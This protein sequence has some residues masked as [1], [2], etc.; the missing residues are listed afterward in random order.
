MEK[1]VSKIELFD[2]RGFGL[3]KSDT[4]KLYQQAI[5][6]GKKIA[7]V[8]DKFGMSDRL[9][10]VLNQ[11]KNLP[12]NSFIPNQ[13][14]IYDTKEV[15]KF[16]LEFHQEISKE[17]KNILS[18]LNNISHKDVS[19]CDVIFL[20]VKTHLSASMEEIILMYFYLLNIGIRLSELYVVIDYQ[21]NIFDFIETDIFLRDIKENK[22]PNF[23]PENPLHDLERFQETNYDIIFQHFKIHYLVS[24]MDIYSKIVT[25]NNSRNID[26]VLFE[27]YEEYLLRKEKKLLPKH[28]TIFIIKIKSFEK[29][30]EYEKNKIDPGLFIIDTRV[31]M[32]TSIHYG[33]NISLPKKINNDYLQDR[34]E[35]LK[36]KFDKAKMNNFFFYSTKDIDNDN[37]SHREIFEENPV[38][39]YI[40]FEKYNV[41]L[42]SLYNNYF[43]GSTSKVFISILKSEIEILKQIGYDSSNEKT[44]S[45]KINRLN[46]LRANPVE[47]KNQIEHL[48]DQIEKE[49]RLVKLSTLTSLGIHPVMIAIMNK[50]LIS[51]T[52][53][54][55]PMPRFPIL[56][57]IAVVTTFNE[58]IIEVKEHGEKEKASDVSE[59]SRFGLE[60][61]KYLDKIQETGKA[62]FPGSI[63]SDRL[64]ALIDRLEIRN[65]EIGVFNLNNFTRELVK[66]IDTF[67]Q[68]MILK[69]KG[70]STYR[71]SY[72]EQ[73][74]WSISLASGPER[75]FPIIVHTSRMNKSVS[76]FIPIETI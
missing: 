60:M 27:D 35:K 31:K 18:A 76:L 13:K 67:F 56:V 16:F 2:K 50:W 19:F 24:G 28:E 17:S 47:N 64:K 26:H 54:G 59:N 69:K 14:D 15:L 30:L 70:Y 72:N 12:I 51:N 58:K 57:F 3:I 44:L 46:D 4:E 37:F 49:K 33:G 20:E 32:L 63:A 38:F 68:P 75:I 48:S 40:Y 73:M 5:Q 71:S 42:F 53:S 36:N 39:N 66:I 1:S 9:S 25:K 41:N 22:I 45:I 65:E 52:P 61:Q 10:N 29:L 34:L 21:T 43:S 74:N 62:V 8:K 7:I 6:K 11:I 55:K 23:L